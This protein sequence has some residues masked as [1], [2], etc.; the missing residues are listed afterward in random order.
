MGYVKAAKNIVET[1]NA[2]YFQRSQQE[3][4]TIVVVVSMNT[5]WKRNSTI[6]DTS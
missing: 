1:M 4:V 5:I 2:A 6:I 3:P